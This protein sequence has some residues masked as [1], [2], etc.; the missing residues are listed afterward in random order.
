MIA[1]I[2]VGLISLLFT[3]LYD[4]KILNWGFIASMVILTL[5]CAVRY[6]WGTDMPQY[7]NHFDDYGYGNVHIW[8]LDKIAQ[9]G[10]RVAHSREFGWAILNLMCQ[11]IGFFGM[12]ILLAVFEGFVIY[13]F[14]K[15]Y[16]PKGYYTIAVFLYVFNTNLMVLGCSMMRQWLAMCIALIAFRFLEKEKNIKFVAL[17]ILASLFHTSALFCLIFLVFKSF[18]NMK[19]T[20]DRI[21]LFSVVVLAWI[22]LFGRFIGGSLSYVFEISRFKQYEYYTTSDRET[23]TVGLGTLMNVIVLLLCLFSLNRASS[24]IKKLTWVCSGYLFVLPFVTVFPLASRILFYFELF[25]IAVIPNGVMNLLSSFAKWIII[26]WIIFWYCFMF[27][28]FFNSY[29]WQYSYMDYHTIF[30]TPWR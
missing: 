5:F 10:Y 7:A 3:Y 9:L 18:H 30:E 11:P 4:R 16:V 12:T 26:L 17:I 8:E 15:Q 28:S 20:K 29:P 25:S 14:I 2:F 23:A 6:E 13:R 22:Y 19:F 24:E 21:A 1:T 27:I